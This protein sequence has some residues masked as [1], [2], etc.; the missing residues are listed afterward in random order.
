MNNNTEMLQGNSSLRHKSR[1][2]YRKIKCI[3]LYEV[4]KTDD[5]AYSVFNHFGQVPTTMAQ[6]NHLTA[7]NL[8]YCM[9]YV[10]LEWRMCVCVFIL[11]YCT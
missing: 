1:I 7:F 6:K 10:R 5:V 3:K 9:L 2:E 8:M 4:W 11:M